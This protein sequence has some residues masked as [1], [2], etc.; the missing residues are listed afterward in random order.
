MNVE[1]TNLIS[2]VND[3]DIVVNPF[4]L[5]RTYGIPESGMQHYQT[6]KGNSIEG[7]DLNEELKKYLRC[8]TKLLFSVSGGVFR[9][10]RSPI[11][12]FNSTLQ[13]L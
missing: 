12:F 8:D 1:V 9:V 11:V 7:F 3:V 4:V 6:H 10:L 2:S 5:A 13:T